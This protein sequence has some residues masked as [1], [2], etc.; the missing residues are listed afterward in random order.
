MSAMRAR[1][2]RSRLTDLYWTAAQFIAHHTVNGCNLQPGDLLGSG[3]VSG[4]AK[5]A[6][7]CRLDLTWRGTEPL[8]M[9]PGE[10]RRF[11]VDGAE[12]IMPSDTW[13]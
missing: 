11:L 3:T 8:V 10:A 7:G 6:R 9:P 13:P 1:I 12:A 5:D 4:K 2:S